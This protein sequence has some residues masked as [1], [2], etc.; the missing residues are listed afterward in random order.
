MHISLICSGGEV[1]AET[2][3]GW[4]APDTGVSQNPYLRL[5]Q[6]L[7][8]ALVDLARAQ[9]PERLLG[10]PQVQQEGLVAVAEREDRGRCCAKPTSE[11]RG[12]W[13]T[14]ARRPSRA[15]AGHTRPLRGASRRTAP[16]SQRT[17]G[18][19]SGPP[20]AGSRRPPAQ[21]AHADESVTPRP[22]ASTRACSTRKC[23]TR[24]HHTHTCSNRSRARSSFEPPYR[25]TNLERYA[26]HSSF[27]CGHGKACRAAAGAWVKRSDPRGSVDTTSP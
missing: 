3:V 10:L 18:R 14:G 23:P 1:R 20:R 16:P 21:R 26:T 13:L 24:R 8:R 25:S 27:T 4:A 2:D 11:V 6:H 22:R 12:A 19:T 9:R 17:C 15:S 5:G 7:D